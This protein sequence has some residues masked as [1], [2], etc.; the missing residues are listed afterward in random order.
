MKGGWTLFVIL[1]G[2]WNMARAEVQLAEYSGQYVWGEHYTV[3]WHY[4]PNA[5]RQ[6][7]ITILYDIYGVPFHF[8]CWDDVTGNPADIYRIGGDSASYNPIEVKVV[9]ADGVSAGAQNVGWLDFDGLMA[10]SF[11]S[12]HISGTLGTLGQAS[13]VDKITGPFSVVDI[14]DP[15]FV[16]QLADTLTIGGAGPHEAPLTVDRFYSPAS[17]N[18]TGSMTGLI[19]IGSPY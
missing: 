16:A 17:I 11:P 4:P 10:A 6:P 3:A 8:R 13:Y 2:M 5:P 9:A 12:L 15:L 1:G 18:I 19:E 14:G 7:E